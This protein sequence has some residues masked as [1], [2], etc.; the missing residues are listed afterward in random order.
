VLEQGPGAVNPNCPAVQV[1]G[2]KTEEFSAS[3][4]SRCDVWLPT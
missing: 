2:T 1:P 4:S 3:V